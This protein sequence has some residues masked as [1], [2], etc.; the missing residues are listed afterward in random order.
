MEIGWGD[1]VLGLRVVDADGYSLGR[2]ATA[3]CSP[4]PLRVV[5]LVVRV[6]GLRRRCRAVLAS[7][8]CWHDEAHT[9]LRVSHRRAQVLSSPAADE[10]SL[11]TALGRAPFEA[12]YALATPAAVAIPMPGASR[13]SPVLR[14]Q[15]AE[16]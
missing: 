14:R 2:V 15:K 16:R 9:V 1:V 5:W 13:S 10:E 11:D 8:A 6:P 12:F 7:G 4:D 3:Y